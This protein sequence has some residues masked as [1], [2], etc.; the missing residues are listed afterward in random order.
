MSVQ[1]DTLFQGA[2][3]PQKKW[4]VPVD[5]IIVAGALVGMVFIGT[6]NPLFMLAYPP[7]HL[8][9]MGICATDDRAFRLLFMALLTKA[10]C[11]NR[12]HWKASSYSPAGVRS[13]KRGHAK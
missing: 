6:G 12:F 5:V 11:L 13:I 10:I 9:A 1:T 4:G 7:V 2:T 8:V 3:R